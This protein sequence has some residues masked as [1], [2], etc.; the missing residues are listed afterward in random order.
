M[1]KYPSIYHHFIRVKKVEL[2]KLYLLVSY[3]DFFVILFDSFLQYLLH[4]TLNSVVLL[5]S[6]QNHICLLILI[7]SDNITLEKLVDCFH[8]N[9][10]TAIFF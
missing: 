5:E 9:A 10:N 3:M 7:F 4:D 8:V 2:V 6:L 1:L